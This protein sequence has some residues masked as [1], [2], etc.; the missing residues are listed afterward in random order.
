MSRNCLM[1]TTSEKD[2]C[3]P[4]FHN[5]DIS[6]FVVLLFLEF[7]YFWLFVLLF[8]FPNPCRNMQNCHVP[9]ASAVSFTTSHLCHLK[10]I[11][12]GSCIIGTFI[13]CHFDKLDKVCVRQTVK[14]WSL[15][16]LLILAREQRMYRP[17]YR[18]IPLINT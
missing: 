3:V 7:I 18:P 4:L 1:R 12:G 10:A 16:R 8:C 2:Y 15:V 6:A 14:G 17:G 13:I 11:E 9:E 5:R